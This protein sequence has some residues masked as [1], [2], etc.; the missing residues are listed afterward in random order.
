MPL[1]SPIRATCPA[2][3]ILLDFLNTIYVNLCLTGTW[4]RALWKI[5]TTR[6]TLTNSLRSSKMMS[7]HVVQKYPFYGTQTIIICLQKPVTGHIWLQFNP[8]HNFRPR[9]CNIHFNIIFLSISK[10]AK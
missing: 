2:H 10:S 6:K 9:I 7:N 5:C 4:R 1:L 3:L 8:F